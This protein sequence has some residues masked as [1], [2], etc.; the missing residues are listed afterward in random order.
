MS[1]FKLVSLQNNPNGLIVLGAEFPNPD[2]YPPLVANYFIASDKDFTVQRIEYNC[3]YTMD[4]SWKQINDTWV[5]TA[6]SQHAREGFGV[7]WKIDWEIVNDH[8]PPEYFDIEKIVSD[9][10]SIPLVSRELGEPILLENV[11]FDAPIKPSE[12]D[13]HSGTRYFLITLGLLMIV[14]SLIKMY[15]D[16]R[17]RKSA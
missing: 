13:R 3:G 1:Q 12:T 16:R 6:F 5:P 11:G 14:I 9:H 8:V 4:I 7:D 10:S 15:Y 2:G 17:K